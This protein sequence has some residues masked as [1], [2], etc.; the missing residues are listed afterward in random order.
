MQ[1]VVQGAD[2]EYACGLCYDRI[3]IP[4]SGAA[5]FNYQELP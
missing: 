2:R 4:A 1:P 3:R 5:N